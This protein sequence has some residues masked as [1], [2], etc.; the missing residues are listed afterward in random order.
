MDHNKNFSPSVNLKYMDLT[1][2]YFVWIRANV[3]VYLPENYS[4]DFPVLVV[5]F[6]HQGKNYKYRT[7]TFN[8]DIIKGKWNNL[9]LDYLTPEVRSKKDNLMVYV[10]H[11]GKSNIYIDDFKVEIF[12]DKNPNIPI[13][14]VDAWI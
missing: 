13:L 14:S 2:N 6:Q 4:D 7:R 12:E 8:K 10:W 1:E 3:K 9:S 5:T 11:R